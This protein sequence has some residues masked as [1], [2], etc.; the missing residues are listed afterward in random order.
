[1]DKMLAAM[2]RR[3]LIAVDQQWLPL[4]QRLHN[5]PMLTTTWCQTKWISKV[6][7]CSLFLKVIGILAMSN[8]KYIKCCNFEPFKQSFF[9]GNE[10]KNP[11]LA[12]NFTKNSNLFRKLQKKYF[13]DPTFL[14]RANKNSFWLKILKFGKNHLEALT[15]FFCWSK[16]I[17]WFLI[18]CFWLVNNS[19]KINFYQKQKSSP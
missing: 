10:S 5:P 7:P 16:M 18:F 9:K 15:S 8:L 6:T 17:F 13:L 11:F 12:S 14:G 19:K 4:I 3:H 1:M 2:Y